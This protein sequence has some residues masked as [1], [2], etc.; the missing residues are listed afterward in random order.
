MINL[1]KNI[2]KSANQRTLDQHQQLVKEI[3]S[4]EVEFSEYTPE[5]F[6]SLKFSK[7]IDANKIVEI[8][9]MVREASKRTLGLRHFD[10]QVIGGLVLNNGNIA[11]MKTGEGL[12]LIHI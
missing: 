9:A 4:R 6:K 8:F 3:N 12:S 5:K 1:F 10:C 7:P 2:F 11:E